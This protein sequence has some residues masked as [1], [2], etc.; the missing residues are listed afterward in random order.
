MN[1][2]DII[3]IIERTLDTAEKNRRE[4]AELAHN[5]GYHGRAVE[6]YAHADLL[7]ELSECFEE[8]VKEQERHQG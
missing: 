3:R 7:R 6:L 1:A 8:S 4:T 2:Y 5:G